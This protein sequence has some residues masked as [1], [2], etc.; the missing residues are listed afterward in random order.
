MKCLIKQKPEGQTAGFLA[1][2]GCPHW[3]T[4]LPG[5]RGSPELGAEPARPRRT[6]PQLPELG[7]APVLSPAGR[8]SGDCLTR[9]GQSQYKPRPRRLGQQWAHDSNPPIRARG[10]LFKAEPAAVAGRGTFGLWSF[11]PDAHLSASPGRATSKAGPE[12]ARAG[13]TLSRVSGGN[14]GDTNPRLGR[15]PCWWSAPAFAGPGR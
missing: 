11:G 7:P 5:A 1:R 8:R 9:P 10:C 6:A 14:R 4:S 3:T 2:L 15:G 12:S 13:R